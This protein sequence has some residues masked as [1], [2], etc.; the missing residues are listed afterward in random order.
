MEVK[1]I[2]QKTNKEKIL[3]VK[4]ILFKKKFMQVV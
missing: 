3:Q 4:I 2:K 1:Q